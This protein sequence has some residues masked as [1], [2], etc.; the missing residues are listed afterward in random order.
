MACNSER[1]FQFKDGAGAGHYTV[2]VSGPKGAFTATADFLDVD[3][4]P[5]EHWPPDLIIDPAEKD[6]PLE[7]G[8][9]YVVTVV[10]QCVTTKPDPVTVEARVDSEQY[11]REIACVQGRFERVI[12]FIKRT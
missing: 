8:N 3:T 12:H 10:V 11:C 4:P 1:I 5:S 9:A 2:T 7:G 6:R